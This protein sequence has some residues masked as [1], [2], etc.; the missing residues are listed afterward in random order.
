[1]TQ[2][3]LCFVNEL[4][5]AQ[6]HKCC[7]RA[8]IWYGQISHSIPPPHPPESC[9]L[10]D[11]PLTLLPWQQSPGSGSLNRDTWVLLISHVR[12]HRYPP[13]P[14]TWFLVIPP[15]LGLVCPHLGPWSVTVGRGTLCCVSSVDP[16]NQPA[17][18][19]C[20]AILSIVTR[21]K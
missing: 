3:S 7:S 12:C 19:N 14:I 17:G 16:V 18:A 5:L 8:F 15:L 10:P 21:K 11:F 2:S 1:M 20:D 13:S 9:R 6:W 4:W